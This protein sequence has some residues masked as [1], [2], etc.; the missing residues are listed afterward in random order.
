MRCLQ[1]MLTDWR[2]LESYIPND[3]RTTETGQAPVVC[4][5]AK[6]AR[7]LA[8]EATAMVQTKRKEEEAK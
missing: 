2:R 3:N 1:P 8:T 6:D 5:P 4:S 7:P